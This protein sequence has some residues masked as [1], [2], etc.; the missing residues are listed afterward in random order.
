ML[1]KP[2][3]S[4]IIPY[5]L[6]RAIELQQALES[7]YKQDYENVEIILVGEEYNNVQ[8]ARNAG[9]QQSSGKYIAFLDCDDIFTHP[10]KLSIQ[11][12]SMENDDEIVLSLTWGLDK[13]FGNDQLIRPKKWWNFEELLSGFHI[14]CTSTFMIRRSTFDAIG[15]MDI[16]LHDSHEY[17]LAL[18]AALIGKVKC[19]PYVCVEFL[20][21]N[22]GNW[23]DD[24]SK[25][26]KGMYQ[27]M[28]K[29]G[30]RFTWDR[31]IKSVGCLCIYTLGYIFG[32]S[33]HKIFD[34][35]KLYTERKFHD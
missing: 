33:T 22:D 2:L 5:T 27:M 6:S 32:H 29:W 26:I 24:W 8:E 35:A 21:A 10:R 15:G 3:V 30:F 11:V 34:I 17:D 20:L 4:V 28:E 19:E 14:T 23:S 1:N 12:N 13:R 31:W 9:V 7:V 16:T 25:K 18:R